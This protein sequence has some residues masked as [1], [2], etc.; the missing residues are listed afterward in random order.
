[1]NGNI[2]PVDPRQLVRQ[3]RQNYVNAHALRKLTPTVLHKAR[4]STPHETPIMEGGLPQGLRSML[5]AYRQSHP[6]AMVTLLKYQRLEN[7]QPVTIVEDASGL[8]DEDKLLSLSQ[9]VT[10]TT[11]TDVRVI[12]DIVVASI[13]TA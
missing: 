12:T 13:E 10:L 4:I 7:G 6:Q 1:M 5:T 3:F 11:S 8:P 9:T 2:V